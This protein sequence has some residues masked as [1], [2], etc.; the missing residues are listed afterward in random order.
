MEKLLTIT[1]SVMLITAVIKTFAVW[2]IAKL[3]TSEKK[4]IN[5]EDLIKNN[6][7]I[8]NKDKIIV[9]KRAAEIEKE[10][11]SLKN[12]FKTL[13]QHKRL[14]RKDLLA[15]RKYL[16]KNVKEYEHKKFKNDAH[17]IYTMLLADDLQ[18]KHINAI[19]IFLM[20]K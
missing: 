7:R 9:K 15:I 2:C 17:A 3:T 5:A 13:L 10:Y 6:Y 14:N 16:S 19:K 4:T 20:D 12:N 11:L 8:N 1:I 18:L